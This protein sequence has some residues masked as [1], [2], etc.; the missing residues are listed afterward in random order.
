MS[1]LRRR[2]LEKLI[3]NK[4]ELPNGYIRLDY[5]ESTGTQWIDTG[6]FCSYNGKVDVSCEFTKL[7]RYNQIIGKYCN[8]KGGQDFSIYINQNNRL[9]YSLNSGYASTSLT[10]ELNQKYNFVFS[11]DAIYAND[12]LLVKPI[13]KDYEDSNEQMTLFWAG[14]NEDRKLVGRIY[15]AKIYDKGVLQRDFIPCINPSGAIGMFDTV[16]GKFYGNQGSGKFISGYYVPDGYTILEYIQSTGTQY[17]DTG[18]IPKSTDCISIN[19]IISED[20]FNK[21]MFGSRTSGNYTTSKN[22]IYLNENSSQFSM[23]FGTNSMNLHGLFDTSTSR[24]INGLFDVKN[25]KIANRNNAN[26][27][28]ASSDFDNTATQPY[29][30]FAFNNNGK[31]GAFTSMKLFSFIIWDDDK[32]V[33]HFIPCKTNN[34][35]IGL[36]DIISKSFF[37]NSGTGEFL[38][39]K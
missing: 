3:Q 24:V 19:C 11:K 37:K 2:L 22:Q 31:A 35:E 30:L 4:D 18:V 7:N 21:V 20:K 1:L 36:Y 33:R 16:G 10:V 29:Y 26:F 25:K 32:K 17:I 13:S 5:I 8:V 12:V 34:G 27:I 23:F 39:P 14:F 15:Q 6:L 28:G 38:A 9:S